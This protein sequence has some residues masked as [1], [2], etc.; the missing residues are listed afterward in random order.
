MIGEIEVA[1]RIWSTDSLGNAL[2]DI[3]STFVTAFVKFCFVILLTVDGTETG[4]SSNAKAA[5]NALAINERN[6]ISSTSR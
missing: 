2:C 4:I 6:N 3:P 1:R 5:A